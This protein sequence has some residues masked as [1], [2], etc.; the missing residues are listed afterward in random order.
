MANQ[1]WDDLEYR[2]IG[3]VEHGQESVTKACHA[4]STA[5]ASSR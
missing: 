3:S 4:L 1:P 5:A 2:R